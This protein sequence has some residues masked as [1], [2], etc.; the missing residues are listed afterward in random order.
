M[1][2]TE[3]LLLFLAL[4]VITLEFFYLKKRLEIKKSKCYS[5]HKQKQ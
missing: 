2:E 1:N 4:N 5:N 3:R